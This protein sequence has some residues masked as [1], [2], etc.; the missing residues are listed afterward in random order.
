[1]S[2]ENQSRLEGAIEQLRN[3]QT[4]LDADGIMVGVSREALD[5]ALAALSAPKAEVM[6]VDASLDQRM[7]AAGMIP[8]S[9]LLSGNTP[10][11]KW[12]AHTG[13]CDLDTFEQWLLIRYREFMTMKVAYELGDKDEAD[14]LY[15]WVLAHAGAF[16]EVVSNFRAMKEFL[17]AS[18]VPALT[19]EA[20]ERAV[21]ALRKIAETDKTGPIVYAEASDGMYYASHNSPGRFAEIALE[22][23]AAFPSKGEGQP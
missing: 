23:L 2:E 4:Q 16:G 11:E 19:D 6:E 21:Q 18:P 22:A 9:D 3:H 20:V 7:K 17:P 8:L 15:E 1:M 14:E 12:M 13:V 5:M 10:L